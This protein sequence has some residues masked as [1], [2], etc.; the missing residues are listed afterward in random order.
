[1]RTQESIAVGCVPPAWQPYEWWLPLGGH[2]DS[3]PQFIPT[4]P[5]VPGHPPRKRPGTRD[6]HPLWTDKRLEKHYL[7]PTSLACGKNRFYTHSLRLMSTSPH[8]V[9]VWFK[10]WLWRIVPKI[11]QIPFAFAFECN[12]LNGNLV[13]LGKRYIYNFYVCHGITIWQTKW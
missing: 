13:D 1:M 7:P 9:K 4:P 11:P 2:T 3:L 10:R 6:T 5:P 8:N 12:Q